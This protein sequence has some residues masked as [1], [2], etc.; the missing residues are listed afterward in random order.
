M[1]RNKFQLALGLELNQGKV[2]CPKAP[3]HEPLEPLDSS[4]AGS[5]LLIQHPRLQMGK[6]Q[7]NL[8]SYDSQLLTKN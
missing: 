1:Y 6:C 7:Q 5:S 4:S 8:A 2:R 3:N